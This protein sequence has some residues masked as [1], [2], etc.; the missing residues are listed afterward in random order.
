MTVETEERLRELENKNIEFED[1]IQS[2]TEE[3]N[4]LNIKNKELLVVI[5]ALNTRLKEINNLVY[6]FSRDKPNEEVLKT[7]ADLIRQIDQV[8]SDK[9]MVEQDLK[10]LKEALEKHNI[11]P[12]RP[13]TKNIEYPNSPTSFVFDGEDNEIFGESFIIDSSNKELEEKIK[14]LEEELR[15]AQST[16]QQKNETIVELETKLEEMEQEQKVPNEPKSSSFEMMNNDNIKHIKEVLI[17]FLKNMPRSSKDNEMLL[18]IVF[19]MLHMQ[20]SEIKEIR[21]ARQKITPPDPPAKKK[22]GLFGRMMK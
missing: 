8:K 15:A 10:K 11:R 4:S 13:E 19:S 6:D 22:S 21:L 12:S 9:M 1:E 14:N 18:D 17:K 16:I 2:L 5:N 20:E 3:N 7:N